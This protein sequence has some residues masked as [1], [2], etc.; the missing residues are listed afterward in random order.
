MADQALK[1]M[2]VDEFLTWDDGT[3]TRYE[4]DAGVVS[5]VANQS[6]AH[7]T[8]KGA[9]CGLIGNALRGRSPIHG[10]VSPVVRINHNTMW[11]TDFAVNVRLTTREPAELILIVE[12]LSAPSRT[13][14]L[15]RKLPDY[16]ALPYLREIWM[17]DAERRWVQV[18]TRIGDAVFTVATIM[19]YA[20][21]ESRLLN[22]LVEL[23]DIYANSGL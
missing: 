21:F 7:G 14:D 3:D 10:E 20:V 1:L 9:L 18:W 4:L 15:G 12:V 2:T 8:I 6:N 5:P 22:S 16:I 13:H 23:D 17:V 19:G 11:M